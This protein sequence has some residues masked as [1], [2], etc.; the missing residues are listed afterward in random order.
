M[1][2]TGALRRIA[3]LC[4]ASWPYQQAETVIRE[5]TGIEVSHDHIKNL[6]ESEASIVAKGNQETYNSLY[7]ESLVDAVESLVDYLAYEDVEKSTTVENR[8]TQQHSTESI[9][10]QSNIDRLYM[11]LDGVFIGEVSRKRYIEAKVGIVFT[12]ER[13]EISKGRN[14]LLNKQYVGTCHTVSEFSQKLF[15]CAM[16]M[17]VDE[18]EELIVLGDGARWIWKI[19]ETQ[20]P[21]ATLILDWWHLKERVWETVD[22]LKQNHM[23][24]KDAV[25]WGRR[26]V[27]FR[28]HGNEKR[29]KKFIKELGKQFNIEFPKT[30]A[31]RRKL[32]RK[33]LPRLYQYINNN[34]KSI[35]N[36]RAKKEAGYFISSVF[37]EK[38]IDILVCR[39]QK[40]RGMNW[41][42]DGA[43]NVL[44]LRELILNE[45]WENHWQTQMAA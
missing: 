7:D 37:A 32:D 30:A 29:A 14:L 15:C 26:L 13:A 9:P 42:R 8:E 25:R 31:Q 1:N 6:C 27:R 18:C 2:I 20:Y 21:K 33:S 36:Y 43:D 12:D 3:T 5:L 45:E 24:N 10:R 39:R 22:S 23:A 28:W 35:V 41:S 17:G 16:E 34:S 40:L 38:A 44:S 19:A 4:G 11:G